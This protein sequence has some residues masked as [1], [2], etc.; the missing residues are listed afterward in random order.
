LV[1]LIPLSSTAVAEME[2]RFQVL[3]DCR[4][5][6]GEGFWPVR[7]EKLAV[8][9]RAG[10]PPSRATIQQ[11]GGG[12]AGG[13][14]AWRPSWYIHDFSIQACLIRIATDHVYLIDIL[15]Q[16]MMRSERKLQ[17]VAMLGGSQVK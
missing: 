6:V 12:A 1:G 3:A 14:N 5:F 16:V 8:S 17:T 4:A 7:L 9:K 13:A 15:W 2:R 10:R 11:E